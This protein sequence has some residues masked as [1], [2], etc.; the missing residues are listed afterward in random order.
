[1]SHFTEM[2]VECL[3]KQESC[4]IQALEEIFGKGSVE[5]SETGAGLY[6]YHGDLRTE[7]ATTN[8]NYAPPC[9][10][11]IRRKNIGSASN[12]I[13]FR[14][15]IN[16]TYDAYVSDYDKSQTYNTAKQ[17]KMMQHY[18]SNVT[19]KQLKTQGYQVKKSITNGNIVLI[20]SKFKA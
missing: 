20:G 12:D 15:N 7:L 2:K 4:F 6:G 1:M 9:H 14:R 16:G 13:G 8:P 3:Q 5:I 11:I 19:I 10:L 18:S 17:N